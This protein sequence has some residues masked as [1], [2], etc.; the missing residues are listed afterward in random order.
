[1]IKLVRNIYQGKYVTHFPRRIRVSKNENE[2]KE[3]R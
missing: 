2:R 1:M 3:P